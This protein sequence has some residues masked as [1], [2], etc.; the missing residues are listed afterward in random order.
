MHDAWRAHAVNGHDADRANGTSG[1]EGSRGGDGAGG[2]DL[3]ARVWL[4]RLY[5]SPDGRD[6]VAMDSRRRLFGGLLRRMLVLRDDVC[7]TPWCEAPIVHADHA[8]PV[9]ELG[10]TSFEE[11][12]GKCARCNHTKEAPGWKTQVIFPAADGAGELDPVPEVRPREGGA[13][14]RGRAGGVDRITTSGSDGLKGS[15]SGQSG[16]SG[17]DGATVG[18]LPTRRVL[19]VTTPL[20]HRYDSEPPPLLGWGSQN[21]APAA[22]SAGPPPA[23]AGPTTEPSRSRPPSRSRSRPPSRS[24]SRPP[25]RS[26][27]R[28]PSRRRTR[29]L[30]GPG[31]HPRGRRRRRSPCGG[32]RRRGGHRSCRSD[33]RTR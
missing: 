15:D 30:H 20:G 22:G 27:S 7:T 6:L 28:P 13:S 10:E 2:A 23:G 9:R 32:R 31:R 25:S 18:A 14:G 12:N 21:L 17:S 19:Q 8:T 3:V 26:R 4:R 1:A 29:P 16:A 11:G 5:A 24:R 33:R